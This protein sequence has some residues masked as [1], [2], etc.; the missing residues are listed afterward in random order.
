MTSKN[1]LFGGYGTQ[2]LSAAWKPEDSF[3]MRIWERP[4]TGFYVSEEMAPH[5]PNQEKGGK[6]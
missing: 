5:I 2:L 1:S 6:A 4:D 3:G